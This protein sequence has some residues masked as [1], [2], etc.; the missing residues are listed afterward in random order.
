MKHY[1]VCVVK[2]HP[3]ISN[4]VVRIISELE[5]ASA[6][7][8][9]GGGGG[10]G[11]RGGNSKARDKMNHFKAAVAVLVKTAQEFVAQAEGTEKRWLRALQH[12][13]SIRTQLQENMEKLAKEM[14]GMEA[15]A[16]RSF[17]LEQR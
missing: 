12:E 7:G 2:L 10:G 3:L 8:G 6:S 13:L 17:P 14:H 9:E 5:E 4:Q 15:E 1:L 11:G 16:R